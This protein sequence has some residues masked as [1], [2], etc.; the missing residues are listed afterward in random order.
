MKETLHSLLSDRQVMNDIKEGLAL[1]SAHAEFASGPLLDALFDGKTEA[2]SASSDYTTLEAIILLR[3]RPVLLIQDGKW[4]EPRSAEIAKWLGSPTD[5]KNTLVPCIPSIGRV[6]VLNFSVDYIGTG[7]MLKEDVLITN[8]HVVN[9]FGLTVGAG[10]DFKVNASGA[11][12]QARVDFRREFERSGTAQ[13][14]IEQIMFIEEGN[15]LRPDMALLRLNHT[16]GMLP[17]PIE[18]DDTP[19]KTSGDDRTC[20]AV[21]GYPAEDGRNDAFAMRQIFDGRYRVKRLSPGRAM[22]VSPDGKLLEHDCT[23][24]GGNS[25]SPVINLATGKAC[26]LHFAGT[27][28]ERNFA[29]TSAWLN[30]RLAELACRTTVTVPGGM[31]VLGGREAFIRPASDFDGC[32]G[33]AESFLGDDEELLVPLPEISAGLQHQVAAVIG[34]ENGVL[35]YT[36]FS[37][38]MRKDRRMP[39]FT[40]VNIDGDSLFN[41]ARGKDRWYFDER[42][43]REFQ[44]GE[45]L[46]SSN[47]LDRGHLVRRLDPAWGETRAEAKQAEMDTFAFTNCTPLHSRLNQQTWLSLEEYILSNTKTRRFRVSTFAGPVMGEDDLEYRG[48]QIPKEFWKVAVIVDDYTGKLSATGYLLSHS[49][50]LRDIE[51][52]F[53]EFKTYQ[54]S[55]SEIEKKTGLNF[56][57]SLYDP[58]GRTETLAYRKLGD[59]SDII[60]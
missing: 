7:W 29:V 45:E 52:V 59:A 25:G 35:R 33:Y 54:V 55:L 3:G 48:V 41:F 2:V 30:E 37:I 14:G 40:A 8:R 56:N 42:V 1:E 15:D 36:H 10:F 24:L 43:G 18:L 12:Y 6:E 57:L 28:R 22:S 19:V 46:Y 47:S 49:D 51:F 32:Y 4:T 44:I 16:G 9:E 17:K 27:Y 38:I 11:K 5:P 34:D 53:G 13:V 60:M 39:F 31:T 50:Y 23:T 26:G 58:M 20:L 21:I